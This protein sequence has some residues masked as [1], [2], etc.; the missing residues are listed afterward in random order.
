MNNVHAIAIIAVVSL[1][2]II[3]R[4]LPFFVFNEGKTTPALISYLGKVLPYAIMGMLVIYCLKDVS[5]TSGSFG[6]PELIGIGAVVLLH[7][8]KRNTLLSIGLGTVCY[9]LLV[10]LVF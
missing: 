7:L 8:W 3:L 6:I 9:M 2:T 5:F 1:V 10:Q 4:F